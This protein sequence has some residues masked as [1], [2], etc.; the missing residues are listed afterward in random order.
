MQN[1]QHSYKHPYPLSIPLDSL[2]SIE[3]AEE[4]AR[5]TDLEEDSFASIEADEEAARARVLE[6]E[7]FASDEY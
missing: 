5:A 7:D 2:V 1:L 3:A 4:E 6:E